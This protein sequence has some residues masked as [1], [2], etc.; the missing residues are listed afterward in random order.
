[1]PNVDIIEHYEDFLAAAKAAYTSDQFARLHEHIHDETENIRKLNS[2]LAFL[3]QE[4]ADAHDANEE[5]RKEIDKLKE[6]NQTY[7][8]EIDELTQRTT[9]LQDIINNLERKGYQ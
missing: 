3:E 2:D 9:D 6:L 7:E 4:L 1:M 5:N 8:N